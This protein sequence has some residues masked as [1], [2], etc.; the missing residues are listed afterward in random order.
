MEK[1]DN[2]TIEKKAN[3]Y[4]EGKII[5]HTI[6]FNSGEKKTLGIM[7]PGEYE[8]DTGDKEIIEVLEGRMMILLP[9]ETEWKLF[10]KGEVFEIPGNSNYKLAIGEVT[11]YCCSLIENA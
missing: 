1:F 2:V 7:M 4:L 3:I 5:S 10:H 9:Q 8:F 6:T 11:E